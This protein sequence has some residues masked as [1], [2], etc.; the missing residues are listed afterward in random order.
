M[1]RTE[2]DS[3]LANG[4]WNAENKYP[5]KC[6]KVVTQHPGIMDDRIATLDWYDG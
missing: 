6:Y 5:I 1:H 2:L 3:I 4:V